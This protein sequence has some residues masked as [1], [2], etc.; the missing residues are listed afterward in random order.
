MQHYNVVELLQVFAPAPPER[1]HWVLGMPEA[2]FSLAVFS[3]KSHGTGRLTVHVA[4]DIAR[5]VLCGVSAVHDA[6]FV[7]RD[8]KPANI[9]LTVRPGSS[10][11]DGAF[12]VC[13]C[14]FGRAR[15]LSPGGCAS[16]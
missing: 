10:Q 12:R 9:L 7:H 13:L 11:G 6:G 2:D 5:Q 16:A 4:F 14:D 3:G 1:P 8:L 15:P